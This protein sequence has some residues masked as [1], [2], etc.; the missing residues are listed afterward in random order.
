[1]L[2]LMTLVL[3]MMLM[4]TLIMLVYDGGE[5]VWQIKLK[6]FLLQIRYRPSIV[7]ITT[8]E[9]EE[10]RWREGVGVSSQTAQPSDQ[11]WT[12]EKSEQTICEQRRCIVHCAL[13]HCAQQCATRRANPPPLPPPHE[14]PPTTA[15]ACPRKTRR[16][17]FSI[18][19]AL[20]TVS[21]LF[22][23]VVNVAFSKYQQSHKT[24]SVSLLLIL[25]DEFHIR[26]TVYIATS[27][28]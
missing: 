15:G 13:V 11:M 27:I 26:C 16:R 23:T 7:G 1:M 4:M 18:C 25:R 9:E 6:T 12:G 3:L 2:M 19:S 22:I 24:V 17:T 5:M 21:D 28:T 14:S 8:E 20:C 10:R